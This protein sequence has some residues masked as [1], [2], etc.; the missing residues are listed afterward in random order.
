MSDHPA[1]VTVQVGDRAHELRATT[2]ADAGLNLVVWRGGPDD[3]LW[4]EAR[5]YPIH[6]EPLTDWRY[7]GGWDAKG[8]KPGVLC[9]LHHLEWEPAVADLERALRERGRRV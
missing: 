3:R 8:S 7:T 2:Y 4:I 6:G 9:Y 5:R 1:T